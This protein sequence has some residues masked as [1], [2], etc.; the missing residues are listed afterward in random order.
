MCMYQNNISKIGLGTWQI[1]GDVV[2]NPNN[3][4]EKDIN[5]IIYA[6]NNG[7]NHIDT[8]E[9]YSGGKSEEL[10]GKA[11]KHFDRSKLFIA[12]K[13]RE[14]NLTYDKLISS[15]QKS[16]K[17]LQ[18]D[19][20]DLY[21]I[22]KQNSG[23]SI[24]ETCEAL[25]Y[26]LKVGYIKNIGLSNVGISKIE[27]F[28]KYLNKK[29]FAVQNQYNL[30][31]RESQYKGVIDYCRKYNIKF[32]S[33][34]PLLLSFP[35]VKDPMYSKGTYPL[36]DKL[37]EKY[38]VSNIQIVAKWLLQQDNVY[39]IFKS[40]NKK[41]IKEVLDTEKFKLS[42]EDWEKLNNDFP[43]K[44]NKGCTQNEFYELS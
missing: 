4:D 28:N 44:F 41:H 35:G 38:N 16:L 26:L 21:Y 3:D 10:I 32:I 12:T 2:P 42:Q 33:W 24:K 23:I 18:V 31:C 39:I 9:S 34:R 40:N 20:I 27:E 30:V 14:W 17:R 13:V 22:H 37:A 6:I 1:G 8:S 11:I 36:L 15:C 7:I 29:V 25:N 43:I 5:A 19:Y